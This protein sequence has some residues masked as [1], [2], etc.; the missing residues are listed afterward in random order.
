MAWTGVLQR[1]SI[2]RRRKEDHKDG[3][4]EERGV[5]REKQEA[6]REGKAYT[7]ER[8]CRTGMRYALLLL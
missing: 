2:R 5:W 8:H 3:T 1:G 6:P 4:K 7:D